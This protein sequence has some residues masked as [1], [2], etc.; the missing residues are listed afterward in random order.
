MPQA[1]WIESFM[2]FTEGVPTPEIFRLWTAITV[3]AGTLERKVWVQT[4]MRPLYPNLFTLLVAP[5]GIGKSNS[6]DYATDLWTGVKDLR[7]APNNMTKAS[8]IDSLAKSN[9]TLISPDGELFEFHS[10]VVPSSEFGVLIPAHDTEFL[11]VLNIVWDNPGLYKEVRRTLAKD[12]AIINP[13]MTILAGSQPGFL[14]T[15]LPEEAWVMG[16]TSRLLMI[17][18]A[19]TPKIDIFHQPPNRAAA[20]KV[21]MESLKGFCSVMGVCD[22]TP[23][24]K[25]EIVRWQD[26][27][28][29]PLPQ[30]SKLQHYLPRR[31]LHILKLSIISCM[32]RTRGYLIGAEDVQRAMTWL[33][34]AEALM[35]DIFRDMV[36]KSDSQVIQELWFYLWQIWVKDKKPIHES[37][38]F[39][40]LQQRLPSEKVLKV[41][42][43]AERSHFIQ[44]HEG[45]S[46][47]SPRP[48]QDFG[49][50]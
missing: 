30:H 3:M 31:M 29:Q 46:S 19:T 5:P 15:L 47:Y 43:T 16:F 34:Q 24:A 26:G 13:Q 1:D 42:E 17:Y 37:V 41:I 49:V 27:G 50:E 22:F 11:N 7:V 9:R 14:A 28:C 36:G 38:L 33:F 18:S 35:P 32:S 10:M 48:K 8:L 12:I 44:L 21:L 23:E 40:F 2:D 39:R 6:I 20:Q 25:R 4:G 45:T